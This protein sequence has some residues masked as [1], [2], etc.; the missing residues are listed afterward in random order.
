M[1]LTAPLAAAEPAVEFYHRWGAPGEL[2]A[3]DAVARAL[4]AKGHALTALKADDA[5]AGTIKARIVAGQPAVALKMHG[6]DLLGWS[7][8]P[9][10]LA[11]VGAFKGAAQ[12]KAALPTALLP[13]MVDGAALHGVPVGMHRS[14]SVWASKAAFDKAGV[15]VPAS[16]AEFNAAAPKF[17]AAGIVPLALGGQD[18]QEGTLFESV[19]LGIGGADFYRAALVAN[20]PAAL[21]GPQMLA[22]F[23]QMRLLSQMVDPA[24]DNRSWSDTAALVARGDAAMQIMGEWVKS[25]F[26]LAGLRP[27][28]DF[29]CFPAP[30]T[31]GSFVFLSDFI[32]VFHSRD[33]AARDAAEALV[34]VVMS[35]AVQEQFNLSKGSIP[36]RLDVGGAAFDA[37]AQGAMA[38]R[39]EAIRDNTM[40]G[41]LT[42]QHATTDAVKDAIIGVVHAHFHSA[43]SDAEAVRQVAEKVRAAKGG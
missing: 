20:D 36:A 27:E 8:Q 12:W 40:L 31:K 19:A 3:L 34:E 21:Q 38:D 6:Q 11:D 1:A 18:W 16:W 5:T 30:G 28:R 14:N 23:R 33:A 42:Y 9:G 37:C 24:Y 17:R 13:F 10:A 7:A 2:K 22:V 25:E 15:K 39:R 29:L 35:K 41:S 32:G 26:L 43:M 4:L